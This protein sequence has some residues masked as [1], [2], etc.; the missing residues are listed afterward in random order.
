MYIQDDV[1]KRDKIT[2]C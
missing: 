1:S 2:L